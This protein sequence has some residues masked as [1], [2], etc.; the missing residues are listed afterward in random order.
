[1]VL[2][3]FYCTYFWSGL[4][5]KILITIIIYYLKK[6]SSTPYLTDDDATLS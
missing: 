2:L 4:P 6:I 1:M 5:A 3:L